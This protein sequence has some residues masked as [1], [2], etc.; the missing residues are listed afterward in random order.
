MS[1]KLLTGLVAPI[2]VAIVSLLS[3]W[4]KEA[5]QRRSSEQVRQRT[6]AYVKDEIAVIEAWIKAHAS[7]EP[8]TVIPETVAARA[9][10]DLDSAYERMPELVPEPRRSITLHTLM[11][12]LLLRHVRMT[13]IVR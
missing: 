10:H 8:S 6:L 7:L 4:S 3:A 5:T 2:L 11:S 9:R 13:P 12:R 1:E